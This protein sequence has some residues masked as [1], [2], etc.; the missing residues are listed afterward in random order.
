[1][2]PIWK[3]LCTTLVVVTCFT[4][5][6]LIAQDVQPTVVLFQNVRVFDGIVEL[7]SNAHVLFG[8]TPVLC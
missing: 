1:M 6:R 4:S 2:L 3:R 8:R 5:V 7:P